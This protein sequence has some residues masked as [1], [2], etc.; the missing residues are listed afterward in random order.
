MREE[1]RNALINRIDRFLGANVS[2]PE[3]VSLI[4][5]VESARLVAQAEVVFVGRAWP[6]GRR[7]RQLEFG[8]KT[9]SVGGNYVSGEIANDQ[10]ERTSLNPDLKRRSTEA[11]GRRIL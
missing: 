5:A 4:S 1:K 8:G 6:C 11:D 7:S 10:P 9:D 2:I 3:R